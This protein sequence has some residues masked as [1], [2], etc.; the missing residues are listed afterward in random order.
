MWQQVIKGIIIATAVAIDMGK[1]RKKT[2]II[3]ASFSKLYKK[4]K[5]GVSYS[6]LLR[7]AYEPLRRSY[8]AALL[9]EEL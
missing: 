3:L 9:N 6:L 4:L 1:Y 7:Q 5:Q 2:K 8:R